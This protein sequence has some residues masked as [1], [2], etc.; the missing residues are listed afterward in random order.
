MDTEENGKISFLD[1]LIEKANTKLNFSIFRKPT[2]SGLG[3]SFFSYCHFNFKINA[4]KT[5]LHRAFLISS[6]YSS[7]HNEIMFLKKYFSDNGFTVNFFE[8]LVYKFLNAH[9]QPK[10]SVPTVHKQVLY[11]KLPYLGQVTSKMINILTDNLRKFYPQVDFRFVPVNSFKISSYF[12]FKDRLPT[13]LRSSVI[14]KFTC[15]SCQAGYIGSTIRAFKVRTDEHLGQ[16][17]RTGRRLHSPPHSAVRD[18]TVLC[19]IIPSK[20]NFEIID[21][22]PNNDLRVLE[23]L[24][25]KTH[26]PQLNNALSAAPLNVV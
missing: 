4:V 25:I 23:S 14:Y 24:Y 18:H 16:S 9:Y 15:P 8:K 12:N 21:S 2:F 11:V 22:S 7:F 10:I 3:T 5:L 1:I 20:Q 19:N 26:K 6:S 13:D 17:S